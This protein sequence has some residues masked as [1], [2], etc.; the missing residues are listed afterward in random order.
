MVTSISV[1]QVSLSWQDNTVLE[2]AALELI[3]RAA[4]RLR[5][6]RR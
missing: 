2:A 1:T 4:E 6:G 5:G 3:Q